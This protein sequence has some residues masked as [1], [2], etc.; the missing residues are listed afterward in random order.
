MDEMASRISRTR[1]LLPILEKALNS[2]VSSSAAF[3][4]IRT[5]NPPS[6]SNQAAQSCEPQLGH[7][8]KTLFILDSSY[9]PP[10]RAHLALASSTLSTTNEP[11]PHRLLLLFSTHNA[12]KAP[13]PASFAQRLAMM[14]VFAEDLQSHVRKT[15]NS[16]E[17][18]AVSVDIGLT[19]APYYTDKSISISSTEPSTYPSSPTH[20][21][22]L[23]YDTLTRFLAPRYYAKF[24]PPLSA[25]EPFFGPGHKLLVLLRP[26]SSSDNAVTGDTEEEQRVY[27]DSLADG[28]LE[29]EGLNRQWAKQIGILEGE[30][31][32]AA[33]GVSSTV[34]RRAAKKRDWDEVKR[35]CTPGVAEWVQH[36]ELYQET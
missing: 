7:R 27:I 19:T 16:E 36:Q 12:D 22:L 11:L 35:L 29:D 14:V 26:E 21:H 3:R 20:V 17:S 5:V 2:F 31:V 34:I 33:A 32:A 23:G 1:S 10:S 15:G 24:T 30:D 8:P 9:N 25:L 18:G 4:V 6:A 28:S 13:S